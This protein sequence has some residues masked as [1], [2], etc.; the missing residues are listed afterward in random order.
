P[1]RCIAFTVDDGYADFG[2]VG[3]PAFA[4]YD[5]P[6]TVFLATGF[7]D[8]E[9]WYWWD[10]I[11][12]VIMNT[13]RHACRFSVDGEEIGLDLSS[14]RARTQSVATMVEWVKRVDDTRKDEAIARLA[15]ATDVA[16]PRD[17]PARYAPLTW[18][19]CRRLESAG[20]S[21][22][23]HTVSHPVLSRVSDQRAS[24]EIATSWDR[25]RAELRSPVSVF[26][27]P[28]GTS[29][30]I[31]TRDIDLA[32]RHG[33]RMALSAIPGFITSEVARQSRFALPR[34]GY[35][36]ESD[37]FRQI[38]GG[39]ERAKSLLRARVASSGVAMS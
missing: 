20:A 26:C 18:D 30:D 7:I 28:V 36:D 10:K 34:F 17:P 1:A 5:C 33:L 32:Q 4:S 16:I 22:G 25:V 12:L 23:P 13:S 37:Q 27:Y 3:A 29:A 2:T 15:E 21:F 9:S 39:V 8:G 19:L 14:S 24:V 38:V 35:P 11:E 31:T 6:V